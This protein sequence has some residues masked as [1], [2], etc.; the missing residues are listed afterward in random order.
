MVGE[1]TRDRLDKVLARLVPD[2]SRSTLQRWI[3]DGRVLVDG[4]RRRASDA[5]SA[6][7][8]LE[9]DP[10]TRL[11]SSALPDAE[12]RVEVLYEDEELCVVLKPAGLVVHPARGHWSKTLVNGLLARPGFGGVGAGP[13][14]LGYSPHVRR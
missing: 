4:A 6:G 13:D 8:V 2:V 3:A 14:G 5:V 12:V 1:G 7:A 11:P 9:V 10:G